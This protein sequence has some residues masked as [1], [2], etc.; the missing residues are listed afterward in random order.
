MGGCVCVCVRACV[1][2]WVRVRVS[3]RVCGGLVFKN[4]VLVILV[5]IKTA[6][7]TE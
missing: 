2:A 4:K 1:R 6:Q 7:K 5:I 3:V